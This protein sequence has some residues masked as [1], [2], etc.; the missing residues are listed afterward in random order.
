M[1]GFLATLFCRPDLW[2]KMVVSGTLFLVLY[3]LVF[4]LFDRAFPGYVAAVWNCRTISGR[5]V[6]GVPVEE[7][8]FAFTFGLYW[9]SV[10][11]HVTWRRSPLQ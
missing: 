8:M 7:L 4:M 2:L 10:Y 1:S 11:E 6:F 5:L 3:F 9:S